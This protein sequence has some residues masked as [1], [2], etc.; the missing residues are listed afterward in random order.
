MASL[1]KKGDILHSKARR[2][3]NIFH[4]CSIIILCFCS[5]ASE[6]IGF[7]TFKVGNVPPEKVLQTAKLIVTDYYSILYGGLKVYV[8]EEALS[9]ETGYI[10]KKMMLSRARNEGGELSTFGHPR[11]QKF[12]LRVVPT[13]EGANLEVFAT[14]EMLSFADEIEDTDDAWKFVNQDY[15]VEDQIVD[16]ILKELIKL[17]ELE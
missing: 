14:F 4:L 9:L 7:R 5:C 3:S 12:Y 1:H 15:I 16:A 6:E 13:P 17:G 2:G 8:D 10:E 11:R